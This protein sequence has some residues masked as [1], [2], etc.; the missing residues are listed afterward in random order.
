[1]S[2]Q[3]AKSRSSRRRSGSTRP[4]GRP[5]LL[6]SREPRVYTKPLHRLEPRSPKAEQWTLGYEVIDWAAAVLGITL[7]PWQEWLLIH[8]LELL[9]DGS[10]RFRYSVVLVARQNGKSTIS[11]VLA[12][13]FM[14]EWEWPL[15][16]GTAQDL[17]V[18]EEIW[19]DVVDWVEA[20]DDNDE[21]LYPELFALRDRVVKVNGKKSLSLR[22]KTRYKVK[23]ANRR[24]GRGLSG[25]L[26]MLDE[27]REHTSFAAWGAITKTTMARRE[28]MILCLSN[29]GDA[30]SVV[31]RHLRLTGHRAV[32][33]PDGINAAETTSDQSGPTDFDLDEVAEL[34]GEELDDVVPADLDA[35]IATLF[36]AE[37]SAPPGCDKLDRAGWAWANPAMNHVNGID[38]RDIAAAVAVD[39]EWTFRTEVLCQWEDGVGGGPFPP[40]SW[41]TGQ[42]TPEIGPD[43]SP[44]VA[45]G[46]RM[47]LRG[48]TACVD[49]SPERAHAYIAVAGERADGVAH[50]EI[51][52]K[53]AGTDWVRPWLRD[54]REELGIVAVTGQVHGAPISPLIED[55]VRDP[56]SGVET[57]P[58]GGRDLLE[59]YSVTFDAVRDGQVRHHV[60]P[61]LDLAAEAAQTNTLAAGA[62]L[63]DRRTSPVDVAPLQAFMG[64]LWLK[65]RRKPLPPPPPS[66]ELSV[67]EDPADDLSG[68]ISTMAF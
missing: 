55:L 65:L 27:L 6:G 8:M 37:W 30:A 62:K 63:L 16:L 24:A 60:Q 42:N 22:N 5:K 20:T 1:M 38:E 25:N 12:L 3:A 52:A 39:D 21:P 67:I 59:A 49:M 11:K 4:G 58:L 29:A 48:T 15:V 40:G 7:H 18:A 19:Q 66:P 46:D 26:V 10:L 2:S 31:L 54:N 36:L 44:R 53:K 9:P 56:V 17:D 68:D 47:V 28:A 32:G 61:P 14:V 57:V 34:L 43:G 23:A 35:D 50:V 64:A 13:W 45:A 51:R 41:K 33:D